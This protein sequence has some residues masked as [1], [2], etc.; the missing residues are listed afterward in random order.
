MCVRGYAEFVPERDKLTVRL[1][2]R[3]LAAQ[4]LAQLDVALEQADPLGGGCGRG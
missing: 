1:T 4:P 3:Q 2:T